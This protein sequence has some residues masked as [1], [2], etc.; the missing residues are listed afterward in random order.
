MSRN[1]PVFDGFAHY[2]ALVF[3]KM[4]IKMGMLGKWKFGAVW[5][6]EFGVWS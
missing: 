1:Q 6:F 5:S 4:I 2:S 3:R